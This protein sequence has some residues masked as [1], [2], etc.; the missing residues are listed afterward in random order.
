MFK[1]I[2]MTLILGHSIFSTNPAYCDFSL[3]DFREYTVNSGLSSPYSSDQGKLNPYASPNFSGQIPLKKQDLSPKD[4]EKMS[5]AR[6]EL[7]QKKIPYSSE[8][9]IK[10]IKKN[11]FENV[12]LMLNAG[13]SPNADYFGEYALYYA[14]KKDR[15]KI[16]LLL[17]ERGAATN[18]GFD[19]PLFWAAKN[20]NFELSR[21]LIENGARLDY[22]DLV[23]SKSILYTAIKNGNYDIA[24]LLLESGAKMDKHSAFLI[25]KKNLFEKLGVPRF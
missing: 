4:R 8:E 21:A 6:E 13:M 5:L 2:T 3:D 10:Q 15:T 11:K 18:A 14:V 19:S 1:I 16:A 20:G 24:R 17:I 23:S 9:F 22:T 7:N 12:E 25:K